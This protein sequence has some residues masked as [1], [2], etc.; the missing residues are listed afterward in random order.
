ME[1]KMKNEKLTPRGKF[2]KE[3][4]R[5]GEALGV[6]E[7]DKTFL[8]DD[9]GVKNLF[10]IRYGEEIYNKILTKYGLNPE[11]HAREKKELTKGDIKKYPSKS[12]KEY[13]DILHKW[14]HFTDDEII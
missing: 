4:A 3:E 6:V 7:R 12:L 1:R 8:K 13:L 9:I 5:F 2:D 11:T 14:W 10:I